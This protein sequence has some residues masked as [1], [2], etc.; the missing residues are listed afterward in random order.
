[1]SGILSTDSRQSYIASREQKEPN[2]EISSLTSD[3][4]DLS[5]VE[6]T[7]EGTSPSNPKLD[8]QLDPGIA[9][10]LS[11][12]EMAIQKYANEDTY[13]KLLEKIVFA[14]SEEQAIKKMQEL[15][16]D[17]ENFFL[18]EC[19]Y[20]A[21]NQKQKIVV[22]VLR[23]TTLKGWFLL[24]KHLLIRIDER[25]YPYDIAEKE[26]EFGWNIAHFLVLS[27]N[28]DIPLKDLPVIQ[29]FLNRPNASGATPLDFQF[30]LSEPSPSSVAAFGIEN[31]PS[32]PED[33][34]RLTG[35]KY[36]NRPC[37]TPGAL[38]RLCFENL[39]ISN[40]PAYLSM[41]LDP[42][43]FMFIDNIRDAP[44]KLKIRQMYGKAVPKI[45]HG[46]W[47]CLT[48]QHVAK[49]EVIGLYSGAV[50][51][52]KWRGETLLGD[53]SF[54]ICDSFFVNANRAGSLTQFINH[55]FPNCACFPCTFK[56]MPFF[57]VIALEDLKAN[58]TLFMSYGAKYF[59]H[60]DFKPQNLNPK[61]IT[62][63]LGE[64]RNLEK[65]KYVEFHPDGR[66][67]FWGDRG[68]MK[69]KKL[70][71][72]ASESEAID[73][74]AHKIKLEYLSKYHLHELKAKLKRKPFKWLPQFND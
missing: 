62:T 52:S 64:T 11:F 23:L 29:A 34:Q 3:V 73:G 60:A 28:G 6:S 9:F 55:S 41:F 65:V 24:L 49:G 43:I 47:E 50:I 26:D 18:K 69:E 67:Y 74:W 71:S 61:G 39:D 54:S 46:Q 22:D 2:I 42:K 70:D 38:L 27:G 20:I 1:M 31:E 68:E 40:R 19:M 25:K 32:I 37:F 5:R 17:N 21:A 48:S 16:C 44:N 8:E 12:F 35:S 51:H 58:S 57:V 36:W 14:D 66:R 59:D 10:A 4:Q 72:P 45:L 33:F 63:Y 7:K 53:K 13:A 56:G 30:W 15:P